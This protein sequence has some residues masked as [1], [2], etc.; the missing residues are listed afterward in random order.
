MTEVNAMKRRDGARRAGIS[1][2]RKRVLKN[3][4]R[5]RDPDGRFIAIRKKRPKKKKEPPTKKRLADGGAIVH[6]PPSTAAIMYDG[7]SLEDWDDEELLRGRRRSKNGKFSGRAPRIVPAALHH[8]LTRRRFQRSYALMADSLVDAAMMLRAV[9]NDEEASYAYRIRAAEVMFERVVGRPREHISL[10]V[11][12][13]GTAPAWQVALAQGIV[14]SLD[15]LKEVEKR[16]ESDEPDDDDV[17]DG[18]L[19][20]ERPH[21]GRAG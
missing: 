17:V 3:L 5:P 18:E 4:E 20:E 1:A 10:D 7:A 16:A 12:A 9:V 2:H 14:G 11:A 13:D 8:E 19:V 6:I 15:Q 21:R